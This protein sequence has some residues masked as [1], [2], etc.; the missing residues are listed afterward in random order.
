MALFHTTVLD[1]QI[2]A[3]PTVSTAS[4]SVAT[5]DTDMTEN[6]VEVKCQ[7]VAQ[8]GGS[9][10]PS[11]SNPRPITTYSK[12]NVSACGKNCFNDTVG[13]H[14]ITANTDQTIIIGDVRLKA[15]QTYVISC[16]QTPNAVSS[17]LRNTLIVVGNGQTVYNPEGND[18]T[19]KPMVFTPTASGTYS[20]RLW[21]HT[22]PVDTDYT[23]FQ[24]ELGNTPTSYTAYNGTTEIIPFGQTVANGVLDVT[25]GKLRVTWG[26]CNLADLAWVQNT[27]NPS[28]FNGT[29][30]SRCKSTNI[31]SFKSSEYVS[32]DST[33]ALTLDNCVAISSARAVVYCHDERYTNVTDFKNGVTAT[34]I[35]ELD[36]PIEIQL[37]S[38]QITA[39]LNENNIWCDTGDTEVKYILSVGE[40]LRQ[41]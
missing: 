33:T 31:L 4:G 27:Y 37:D 9:G 34:L 1:N 25:T 7:I 38:T 21:V 41:A 15:N 32:T 3:L 22:L 28:I 36:T 39:L 8:Q 10:T 5:F 2:K 30:P 19:I 24:V 20:I 17:Y 40:A 16:K 12:M 35:Y 6:L 29:L 18:Y 23:E 13:T 14:T 11:P 26:V